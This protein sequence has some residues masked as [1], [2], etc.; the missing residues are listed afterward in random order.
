MVF[1][2][3]YLRFKQWCN[4]IGRKLVL[5]SKSSAKYMNSVCS[6]WDFWE[7]PKK[8]GRGWTLGT[9]IITK[10]EPYY[11][12][13]IFL[14][15]FFSCWFS[16]YIWYIFTLDFLHIYDTFITTLLCQCLFISYRA[17]VLYLKYIYT[18]LITWNIYDI[19]LINLFF[20]C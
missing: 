18:K 4:M 15:L 5:L 2:C 14:T 6:S 10:F 8:I 20:W 9:V 19:F 7:N 13:N 3:V 1:V 17:L 12:Y 16:S 11:M